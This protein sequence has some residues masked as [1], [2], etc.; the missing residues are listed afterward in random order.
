MIRVLL[1]TLGC[2]LLTGCAA[3]APLSSIITTPSGGTPPLQVHEQTSVKLAADNFILIR[4]NV[5]GR[6]RG[7]SLLGIITIVPATL[8]KAMDRLY[9]N[10]QMHENQPQTIAHLVIEQTSSYW[11]LFG[12]P[13]M[14]ARADVV[15]FKPEVRGPP[16]GGPPPFEAPPPRPPD[17]SR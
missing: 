9:N 5:V 4:T 13:E 12:I 6:S 11:I 10:A 17:A 16:P 1:C 14:D 15:E 2:S 8:N 3:I 7:F